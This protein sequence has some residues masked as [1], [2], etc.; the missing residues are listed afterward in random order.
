[1]HEI[2]ECSGT[3]TANAVKA[4]NLFEQAFTSGSKYFISKEYKKKRSTNHKREQH[5][6][7]AIKKQILDIH[8]S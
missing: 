6:A 2:V 5:K 8:V 7:N 4:R 3:A 1:M